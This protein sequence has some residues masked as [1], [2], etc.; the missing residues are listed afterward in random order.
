MS[1]NQ[2]PIELNNL[3]NASNYPSFL[4]ANSKLLLLV[5]YQQTQ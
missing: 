5:N 1:D 4:A 3:T 2:Q